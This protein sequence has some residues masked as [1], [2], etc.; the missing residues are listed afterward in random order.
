VLVGER[1]VRIGWDREATAAAVREA[2]AAW[3]ETADEPDLPVAL[4][5]RGVAVGLLRRRMWLVHFGTPVR[6]RADDLAGATGFVHGMLRSVAGGSPADD[7]VALR[8]RAYVAGSRAVLVHVRDD[9]DIDER[10]LGKRGIDQLPV[11]SVSVR[12]AT[13]AVLHGGR[14]YELAGAIVDA[15]LLPEGA[16]LDDARRHLLALGD[17]ARRSWSWALDQLGDR[18]VVAAPDDVSAAVRRLLG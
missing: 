18:V 16:V 17:G 7:E 2:T 14:L 8:L 15:R 6:H 3:P 5:I 11:L 4:G 13:G 9:V 10:P 12:P 1:A